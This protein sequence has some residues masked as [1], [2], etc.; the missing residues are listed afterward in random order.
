MAEVKIKHNYMKLMNNILENDIYKLLILPIKIN[1]DDI[2][3]CMENYNY[4]SIKIT[5]SNNTQIKI[6]D[7]RAPMGL[8]NDNLLY[9]IEITPED[10]I[11]TYY[12]LN[13]I[14]YKKFITYINKSKKFKRFYLKNNEFSFNSTL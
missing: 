13:Y 9:S 7:Y 2:N 12:S 6:I 14:Q 4:N 5:T 11:T 10:H 1:I 3:Y 8:F